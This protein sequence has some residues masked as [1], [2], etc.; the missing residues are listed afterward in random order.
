MECAERQSASTA[1]CTRRCLALL[2]AHLP[3]RLRDEVAPQDVDAEQRLVPAN[4]AVVCLAHAVKRTFA[5]CNSLCTPVGASL[6][7]RSMGSVLGGAAAVLAVRMCATLCARG[8]SRWMRML[9][10]WAPH[11]AQQHQHF[12]VSRQACTHAS[13]CCAGKQVRHL[14][15]KV[16]IASHHR[17]LF[18]RCG[19]CHHTCAAL[20]LFMYTSDMYTAEA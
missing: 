13:L 6:Q 17:R 18:V 4:L 8:A 7:A 9:R 19:P 10:F 12:S 5:A 14:C 16:Q 1:A 11:D 3:L 2:L 15:G 20:L